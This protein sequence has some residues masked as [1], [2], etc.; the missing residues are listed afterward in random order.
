MEQAIQWVQ[1]NLSYIL[2]VLL[3]AVS[4]F[5]LGMLRSRAMRVAT[6]SAPTWQL[7]NQPLGLSSLYTM[8]FAHGQGVAMAQR[9]S[10]PV[11]GDVVK[12]LEASLHKMEAWLGKDYPK[13]A[14]D[15]EKLV[16]AGLLEALHQ[17]SGHAGLVR[18]REEALKQTE[19][20]PLYDI[21][22][23][24]LTKIKEGGGM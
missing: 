13:A 16:V 10:A 3:V 12:G 1:Q 21:V 24:V 22:K 2:F 7:A 18:A 23:A 9:V 4:F 11:F 15:A 8:G 6:E 14:F 5:S 17:I 20:K 19:P